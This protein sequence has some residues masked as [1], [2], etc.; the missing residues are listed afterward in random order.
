MPL[1][2]RHLRPCLYLR[3]TIAF[4]RPSS[5]WKKQFLP[6]S[7]KL[8]PI[9]NSP[10]QRPFSSSS[11][12]DVSGCRVH[13][14]SESKRSLEDTEQF[15]SKAASKLHW[16]KSPKTILSRSNSNPNWYSWFADG[17]VNFSYNCLD[18]HVNAGTGD[19]DA[20]KKSESKSNTKKS[21][22]GST[23]NAGNTSL[24]SEQDS[25]PLPSPSQSYDISCPPW[26]TVSHPPASSNRPRCSQRCQKSEKSQRSRKY[27]PAPSN[28]SSRS[29]R[30]ASRSHGRISNHSSD[31]SASRY[32]ASVDVEDGLCANIVIRG[33]LIWNASTLYDSCVIVLWLKSWVIVSVK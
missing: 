30:T 21:L 23:L 27:S 16:L 2:L 12:H 29:R 10:I 24:Y 1:A 5:S 33:S 32:H 15:W 14:L 31:D 8:R 13:Y 22:G 18:V 4:H 25:G 9:T 19:E 6:I 7:P 11:P 17:E 20:G 28:R 3:S 26:R